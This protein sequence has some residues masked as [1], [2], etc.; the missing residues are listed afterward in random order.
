M[1]QQDMQEKATENN[2]ISLKINGRRQQDIR[3]TTHAI[4]FRINQEIKF[5]YKKKQH[6][7]QQLYQKQLE[8]A[9]QQND[10]LP[11][12]SHNIC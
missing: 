6:L 2:Y 4:K 3:T 11:H 9:N 12:P 5:L 8:C 1:V 7:N 10:M